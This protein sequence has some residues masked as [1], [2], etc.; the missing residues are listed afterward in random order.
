MFKKKTTKYPEP[1]NDLINRTTYSGQVLEGLMHGDGVLSI[2]L[3]NNNDN[4]L[5]KVAKISGKFERGLFTEGEFLLSDG[6]AIK[7]EQ[8]INSWDLGRYS[9]AAKLIST[10]NSNSKQS[11]RQ[12][13]W[14]G[15]SLKV[16]GEGIVITSSN[17]INNTYN[18]TELSEKARV[19]DPANELYDSL[20]V[21]KWFQFHFVFAKPFAN[22]DMY[23]FEYVYQ[24]GKEQFGLGG[25]I[26][27]NQNQNKDE[28]QNT[29]NKNK[30]KNKD[31][32]TKTTTKG[33][34]DSSNTK[35]PQSLNLQQEL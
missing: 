15:D 8:F 23:T 17:S 3:S 33:S 12:Y 6:T 34:S 4:L 11:K 26:N 21:L 24:Q 28:N 35:P 10:N 27:Q 29:E 7:T 32:S 1:Y 19:R 16:I 31:K 13:E 20:N 5:P 22:S 9:A 30:K 2:Q 14:D 25:T 18:A